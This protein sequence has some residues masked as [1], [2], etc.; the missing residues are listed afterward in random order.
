MDI[1]LGWMLKSAI[2]QASIFFYV[3]LYFLPNVIPNSTFQ[4]QVLQN[5]LYLSQF[6]NLLPFGC[7]FTKKMYILNLEQ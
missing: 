7:V 5:F 3:K 1:Y 4:S 2:F 6:F